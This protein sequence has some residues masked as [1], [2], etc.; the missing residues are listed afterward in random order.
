MHAKLGWVF[1]KTQLFIEN[2]RFAF[3]WIIHY[4]AL[5]TESHDSGDILTDIFLTM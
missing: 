5:P 2:C 4:A 3:R 1:V